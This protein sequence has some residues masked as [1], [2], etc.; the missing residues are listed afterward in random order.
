[1]EGELGSL[2]LLLFFMQV[3][4]HGQIGSEK[5]TDPKRGE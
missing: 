2:Y 5:L 3:A 1:M 4:L